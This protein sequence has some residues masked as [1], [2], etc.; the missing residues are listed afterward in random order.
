MRILGRALLR[1][2]L[3]L[4]MLATAWRFRRRGWYRQRPFLPLPPPEYMKWRLHTA[5]GTAEH[6]PTPTELEAYMRWAAMMRTQ[7]LAG[8]DA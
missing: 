2:R 3:L 6:T 4:L 7:D 1:P 5:Y 8:E